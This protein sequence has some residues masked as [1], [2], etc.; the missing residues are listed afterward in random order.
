MAQPDRPLMKIHLHTGHTEYLML[1]AFLPQQL[2]CE[3]TS[4]LRHTYT[5]RLAYLSLRLF[6]ANIFVQVAHI[7]LARILQ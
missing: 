2:L 1:T 6:L 4:M 3:D 7:R 5:G